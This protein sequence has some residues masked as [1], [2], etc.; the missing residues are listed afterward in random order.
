MICWTTKPFAELT[1]HELYALLRLRSEV[2]VVEQNCVFL[3]ADNL[4]IDAI[5]VLGHANGELAA[6]CRILAPNVAYT[7]AASIGRVV[8][9]PRQRTCGWGKELMQASMQLCEALYP[10]PIRIGAQTYLL[11][12][13]TSL[14]F[15][16]AGD[17]YLEDGIEHIA[18]QKG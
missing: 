14:G 6:A 8:V 7:H 11:K 13:Y 4:D 17:L 5:H 2:F 12:F 16:P 9:S 10:G 18:M 15:V 3:D 1:V